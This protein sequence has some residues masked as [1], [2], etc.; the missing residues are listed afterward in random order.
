MQPGSSQ[1]ASVIIFWT[2]PLEGED[3]LAL[4]GQADVEKGISE[5]QICKESSFSRD[6]AQESIGI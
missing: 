1:L 5:V 2:F 4:W 3:W 6:E